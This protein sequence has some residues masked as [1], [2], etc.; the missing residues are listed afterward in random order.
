MNYKHIL[1]A[2]DDRIRSIQLR[3]EP[4]RRYLKKFTDDHSTAVPIFTG[5]S[6]GYCN[7]EWDT[8]ENRLF[9]NEI[10]GQCRNYARDIS[11]LRRHRKILVRAMTEIESLLKKP[12]TS[13]S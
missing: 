8:K 9:F 1:S 2:I 11:E 13:E 5:P 6:R 4:I 7:T 12:L 3:R 10:D